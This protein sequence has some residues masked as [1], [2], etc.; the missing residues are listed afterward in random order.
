MS[1][2]KWRTEQVPSHKF[3]FIN[4]AD[5]HNSSPW[6]CLR[7]LWVWIMFF[8]AI[9]V[10]CGDI[11]TC[12]ILIILGDW[13]STI[14]PTIDISI[15]RWI[16]TGCILLSFLLLATDFRKANKVIK[17]QDISYAVSNKIVSGFYC[18]HKFDYFCFIERIHSSSKLHDK[19]SFF[20]FFQLKGWKHLVVQAPRQIINIMTLIA[21]MK[22]SGINFTNFDEISLLLPNLKTADK[23]TFCVMVFTSLMFVFTGVA[24]LVAVILWIPLVAKVQ[25][26]LKEYVCYKMDKR[27]D[28][29]IKKT[30]K[31]RAKKLQQQEELESKE[32]RSNYGRGGGGSG[33]AAK[34][35][36]TGT[37][38]GTKRPKP[39]L[40][41]IDVILANASED[42]RLPA[43][44]RPSRVQTLPFEHPYHNRT[45]HEQ[46]LYHSHQLNIHQQNPRHLALNNHN[47]YT[48]ANGSPY[49]GV[50]LAAESHRSLGSGSSTSWAHGS[51]RSVQYQLYHDYASPPQSHNHHQ[52][53]S[54]SATSRG[55]ENSMQADGSCPILNTLSIGCAPSAHSSI[56]ASTGRI[57]PQQQQQQLSRFYDQQQQF[58]KSYRS[59]HQ[60]QAISP[61]SSP[62]ESHLQPV[63]SRQYHDSNP[64]TSFQRAN[65]GDPETWPAHYGFAS[66]NT[67][68]ET[69][70]STEHTSEYRPDSGVLP[71][72][73]DPYYARMTSFKVEYSF[74]ID[75]SKDGGLDSIQTGSKPGVASKVYQPDKMEIEQ[76]DN[77]YRGITENHRFV[78]AN[79]SRSVVSRSSHASTSTVGTEHSY[80]AS[81]R[82]QYQ[83]AQSVHD[84]HHSTRSSINTA[85]DQCNNDTKSVRS[86][87]HQQSFESRHYDS[88]SYQNPDR[89][90]S[91]LAPPQPIF[92]GERGSPKPSMCS[93]SS[94]QSPTSSPRLSSDRPVRHYPTSL[95]PSHASLVRVSTEQ[96]RTQSM[97]SSSGS[98]VRPP[99]LA[100]GIAV[101]DKHAAGKQDLG[102][103]AVPPPP[104]LVLPLPPASLTSSATPCPKER[105]RIEDVIDD[106]AST[107][108]PIKQFNNYL[109]R[110]PTHPPLPPPS[111]PI[112]PALSLPVKN[113]DDSSHKVELTDT[114]LEARKESHDIQNFRQT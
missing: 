105:L 50:A 16:F 41:D 8:K 21:F 4:F 31:D 39:T 11:W 72:S 62:P 77:L 84:V 53:L 82:H 102:R 71:D 80:I 81:L 24:T 110:P 29:I 113:H 27:I 107:L 34:T 87:R 18:L 33:G 65:T 45:Q 56:Q 52:N 104:P 108:V 35:T 67:L 101:R 93:E 32:E 37:T 55:S 42:I 46:S 100:C 57:L 111:S 28:A 44:A 58:Q 114:I 63:Q 86:L 99:S 64:H 12:T 98:Y 40:P 22:A 90:V 68:A 73:S 30:T 10:L 96:L 51:S 112:P 14:K 6:A 109:A 54:R 47:E 83:Q 70:S 7:Y 23:F 17:S 20:V 79:R 9:L 19:L 3:E 60:E 88:A 2:P 85:W 59:C 25:G 38:P 95:S 89:P 78:K 92:M 61:Y 97:S 91:V 69:P 75:S 43:R 76:Y 15:A 48:Y 26:N 74:D 66:E 103:I 13:T 106:I 36:K 94:T 49:G 5:F 1:P